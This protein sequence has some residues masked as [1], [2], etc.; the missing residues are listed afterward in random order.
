MFGAG[1][2]KWR[3]TRSSGHGADLCDTLV[4]MGL[5]VN[6]RG[7]LTPHP[8]NGV[9]FAR[10]NTLM[11]QIVKAQR[12]DPCPD[13]Q[14][15]PRRFQRSRRHWEDRRLIYRRARLPIH[16]RV[17]CSLRQRHLATGPV[18]GQSK[19]DHPPIVRD[20]GP[21][22]PQDLP[23][24]HPCLNGEDQQRFEVWCLSAVA[25]VQKPLLLVAGQSTAALVADHRTTN[26]LH[27]VFF[28][29]RQTPVADRNL[30]DMAQDRKLAD[31]RRRSYRLKAFIAEGGNVLLAQ[32]DQ[33]PVREIVTAQHIDPLALL[34][35]PAL[36]GRDLA[37][38]ALQ[39]LS[40]CRAFQDLRVWSDLRPNFPPVFERVLGFQ[41]GLMRPVFP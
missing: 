14:S 2:L 10:R 32:S 13:E 33:R 34:H 4:S 3:L 24:P 8:A 21:L 37:L 35:G 25:A 30:E 28:C 17:E 27:H 18:L 16:Q 7:K 36:G 6:R 1:A 29:K 9:N 31:G 11:A 41:S 20:V 22:Q 23:S 26:Q 15:T 38:V 40:E 12:F 39:E 19:R 5:P